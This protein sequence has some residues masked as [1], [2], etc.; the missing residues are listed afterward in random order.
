MGVTDY[1]I[2]FLQV[3]SQGIQLPSFLWLLFPLGNPCLCIKLAEA[4]ESID[5]MHLLLQNLGLQI[6]GMDRFFSRS[7]NKKLP[8]GHIKGGG[9]E[10]EL[11]A[12][13]KHSVLPAS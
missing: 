3:I 5:H 13:G 12:G 7:S 11:L 4:K 1:Y 9:G 10:Q 6:T 8:H 2:S